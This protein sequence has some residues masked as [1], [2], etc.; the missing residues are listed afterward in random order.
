MSLQQIIALTQ[1]WNSRLSWDEYFMSIA[2]LISSRSTCDRL[3]VGCVLVQNTRII[4]VGYN[5]FLPSHPHI[6]CVRDGHEKTTVHAEQNSIT[7]C[8]KRGVSTDSAVAYITHYPCIDCCK[9]LCASGISKIFY[10]HNYKNDYLVETLLKLSKITI[11]QLKNLNKIEAYVS[12]NDNI[13][14]DNNRND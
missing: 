10:Y 13:A 9:I 4:S 6:G 14:K 1:S 12:E 2:F 11:I 8:A 3:N 7:D 5:G